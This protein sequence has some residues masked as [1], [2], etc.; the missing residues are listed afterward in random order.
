MKLITCLILGMLDSFKPSILSTKTR[1]N[2][3]ER[4]VPSMVYPGGKAFINMNDRV[5]EPLLSLL[6]RLLQELKTS[7][8]AVCYLG[9]T[10]YSPF[11]LVLQTKNMVYSQCRDIE[12]M[13]L[14]NQNPACV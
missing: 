12:L 14:L 6:I 9:L 4:C 5:S 8:R 13:N 1:F 7:E 11:Q 10:S 2:S 3:E